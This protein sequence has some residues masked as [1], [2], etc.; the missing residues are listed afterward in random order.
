MDHGVSRA[1]SDRRGRKARRAPKVCEV[2]EATR[3]APESRVPRGLL[4]PKA[5]V[6]TKVTRGLWAIRVP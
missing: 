2:S 3:D 6:E 5:L 4:V 1:L